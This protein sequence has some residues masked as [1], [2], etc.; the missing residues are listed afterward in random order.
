MR[1][2]N[3]RVI[4]RIMG[5]RRRS[6]SMNAAIGNSSLIPDLTGKGEAVKEHRVRD[7]VMA[8]DQRKSPLQR[9]PNS[10]EEGKQSQR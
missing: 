6:S 4:K 8:I 1:A 10:C 2:G 5:R 7:M 3:S 9:V